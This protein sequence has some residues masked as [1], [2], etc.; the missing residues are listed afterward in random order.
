M[1]SRAYI[2][3]FS[4]EG[5]SGSSFREGGMGGGQAEGGGRGVGGGDLKSSGG[6]GDAPDDA[7]RSSLSWVSG[8]MG[9]GEG[10]GGRGGVTRCCWLWLG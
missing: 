5:C 10:G 8:C 7:D 1:S 6:A 9:R 3:G 4:K 2:K